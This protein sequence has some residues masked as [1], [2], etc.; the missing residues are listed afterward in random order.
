VFRKRATCVHDMSGENERDAIDSKGS[1]EIKN[2]QGQFC[3][4]ATWI[5]SLHVLCKHLRTTVVWVHRLAAGP[6]TSKVY[7]VSR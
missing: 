5:I 4:P 7:T 1:V 3:H 2:G 6:W